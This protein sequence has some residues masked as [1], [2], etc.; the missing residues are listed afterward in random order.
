MTAT[1]TTLQITSRR[2]WRAWLAKH[3]ASSPGVWLLRH[4]QHTGVTS[5]TYEDLVCEALCFGWVDSLVKRLDDDRY[6]IKVTPRKPT[7]KWSDINRRRW[8]RTRG[9]GPARG[10]R[11]RCGS[12]ATPL[13]VTTGDP[14]LPAYIATAHQGEPESMAVLSGACADVPAQLRRLDSHGQ[15][16]RDSRATHSRVG[17]TPRRRQEARFEVRPV[18]QSVHSPGADTLSCLPGAVDGI[19][20]G[21]PAVGVHLAPRRPGRRLRRRAGRRQRR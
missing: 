9:R 11:P 7:S 14:G 1:L 12:D 6:A 15:A 4:K 5:M 10:A 13:C 17:C 16:T 2:Q 20:A 19:V 8:K 3:H 18:P 21:W